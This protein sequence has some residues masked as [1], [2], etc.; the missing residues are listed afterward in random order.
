MQ[1]LRLF[2]F[3]LVS[4]WLFCSSLAFGQSGT[5]TGLTGQYYDTATFGTLKTTRTD[6]TVNFNWATAI[7]NGTAITNADTFSVAWSGQVEPEFSGLYTFYVTAD[8]GA[9]LWVNDQMLT[10]RTFAATSREMLGQVNLTVGQR[11]NILLEYIEQ[12]GSASVKLEWSCASRA[13]EVIPMTSLYPS[14]LDKVG[15]SLL[16]E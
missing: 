8:D 11:V 15:G 9:R 14:R 7:P 12:T 10:S 6:A 2:P 3:F 13:R 4:T 5:G 1:K 16:K